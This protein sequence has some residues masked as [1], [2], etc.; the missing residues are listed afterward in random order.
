MGIFGQRIAKSRLFFSI[1]LNTEVHPTE[2]PSG[3]VPTMRLAGWTSAQVIA[4]TVKMVAIPS[5]LGSQNSRLDLRGI[6]HPMIPRH[7]TTV[8]HC[9]L[10]DWSNT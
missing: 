2:W 8:A 10:R 9:S 3:G 1:P 6:E 5:L 7:D 4:K